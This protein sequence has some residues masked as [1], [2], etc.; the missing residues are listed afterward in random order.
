[1]LEV[2]TR[3]HLGSS[4]SVHGDD[5]RM[6]HIISPPL[7]K[8]RP[9]IENLI[10]METVVVDGLV[11]GQRENMAQSKYS[12]VCPE[13]YTCKKS[14]HK[15]HLEIQWLAHTKCPSCKNESV[16]QDCS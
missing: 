2:S 13:W 15:Q 1:M 11:V 12:E 9:R 8:V 6:L 16:R 3:G 4:L 14:K 10:T 7:E 5:R